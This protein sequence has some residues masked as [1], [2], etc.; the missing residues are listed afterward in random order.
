MQ[1]MYEKQLRYRHNIL[2]MVYAIMTSKYDN[3]KVSI[4]EE[5]KDNPIS[6]E[7]PFLPQLKFYATKI[8]ELYKEKK[9]YKQVIED[10][11]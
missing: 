8:K 2:K 1:I 3:Q 11:R 10:E 9:S 4:T 6:K 7:Y 5:N